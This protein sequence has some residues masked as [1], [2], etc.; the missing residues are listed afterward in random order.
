MPFDSTSLL[1]TFALLMTSLEMFLFWR[2][3]SIVAWMRS[4]MPAVLL[5]LLLFECKLL[6]LRCMLLLL[7][8]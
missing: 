3:F 4:L 2:F 7:L 1:F 6:L 5:K 8:R